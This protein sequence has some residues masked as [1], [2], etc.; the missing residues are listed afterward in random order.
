MV[1]GLGSCGLVRSGDRLDPAQVSK[2]VSANQAVYPIRTASC[3]PRA[4]SLAQRVLCLAETT[5]VETRAGRRNADPGDQANPPEVDQVC[6]KI[7]HHSP[8]PA[9]L[10]RI[11]AC[12]RLVTWSLLK[13][14]ET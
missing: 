12:A 2:F 1:V 6:I 13:I 5:P 3:E 9:S 4:G 10:P 7:R 8:N 11:A 14:L